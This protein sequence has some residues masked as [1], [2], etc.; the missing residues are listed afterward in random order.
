MAVVVVVAGCAVVEDVATG[1][2]DV[3]SGFVE[4]GASAVTAVAPPEHAATT[5]AQ[6]RATDT[7]ITAARGAT[8]EK[9]PLHSTI[10]RSIAL[11]RMYAFAKKPKWLVGHAL[12]LVLLV[13]FVAAGFWQLSRHDTRSDRNHAV[14]QRSSE[15]VIDLSVAS[16]LPEDA[17]TIEFRL[18]RVT[19]SFDTGT[20]VVRGKSLNGNPGCHLLGTFVVEGA[21]MAVITNRGWLPLFTCESDDLEALSDLSAQTIEGRI[22][23]TQT[24]GRFGAVDPAD[25]VLTTMARVDLDRIQEQTELQ[26]L[27]FYLEQTAPVISDRLA[28]QRLPEP[29]TDA[30]PHLGY[31]VQWFSFA[32]V[33]LVGYPMV[34]RKQAKSR[35]T[36]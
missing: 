18:A 19:G 1:S 25:G 6:A 16:P 36:D 27:P 29:A 28:P 13:I 17:E 3:V 33:A 26:L 15:P 31:A 11:R 4:L 9:V 23:T 12:F 24:R 21:D 34:L 35:D 2:A 5:S 10:S 8:D 20:I 14:Q 7:F 32:V 30:G 22:R